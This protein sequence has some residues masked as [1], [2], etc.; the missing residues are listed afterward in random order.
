MITSKTSEIF[1]SSVK[2]RPYFTLDAAVDAEAKEIILEKH[3]KSKKFDITKDAK[4]SIILRRMRKV[5][6]AAYLS[7]KEGI[8]VRGGLL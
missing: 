4:Y 6:T 1:H 3:P 8:N 7:D 5:I 2:G